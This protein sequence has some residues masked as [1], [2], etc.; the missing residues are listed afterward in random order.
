MAVRTEEKTMK[1]IGKI[2]A[3][4]ILAVNFIISLLMIFSSYGSLAAPSGRWP[5]ASLSGLAFPFLL[6][7]V[8][9]FLVLWLIVWKKAALLPAITVLLCLPALLDCFPVHIFHGETAGKADLTV[10]TYN[11][12]SFG[13]AVNKDWSDTNPVLSFAAGTGA[14]I[15]VFQEAATG[16]V[17]SASGSGRFGDAYPYCATSDTRHNLAVMSRFP[18]ISDETIAFEGSGNSCQYVRILIGQDTLAL[19][20]CHLQSNGLGG[21]E[22]AEYQRFIENPTDSTYYDTSKKVLKKLLKSTSA[23]AGQARLVADRARSETARYVIVCGDF[24]D[25]PLSYSHRVFDRFM[26]DTYARTGNGPGIT[27]HEH[28]LFYRID[29]IFCSRNMTAA[30]SRVDRSISESDHYPVISELNFK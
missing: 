30:G 20:N 5:L 29:H 25:T 2:V 4:P 14:D 7:A 27:Y 15:L 9:M 28:R 1:L 17:R 18:V 23:R 6:F 3:Y 8:L 16:I 24:N 11:T 21:D 12:R 19:Y 22:I 10:L 26:T 13:T